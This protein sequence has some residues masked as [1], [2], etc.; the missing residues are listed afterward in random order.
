MKLLFALPA[1]RP[2]AEHGRSVRCL[3]LYLR[4]SMALL[5][6]IEFRRALELPRNSELT[7]ESIETPRE[8]GADSWLQ[9]PAIGFAWRS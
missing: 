4:K 3:S 5:L 8:P 1:G 2:A 6:A 9:R 7:P